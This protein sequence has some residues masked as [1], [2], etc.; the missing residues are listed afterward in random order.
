MKID[1]KQ[2]EPT[3]LP[4][5]TPIKTAYGKGLIEKVRYEEQLYVIRLT[6]W[7]LSNDQPVF[8]TLSIPGGNYTVDL[9]VPVGTA[10]TLPQG[11]GKV[12]S[13]RSTDGIYEVELTKWTL[14]GG[15]KVYVYAPKEVIA[16]NYGAVLPVTAAAP[17][18]AASST[19]AA[20]A[21]AAPEEP[22]PRCACVIA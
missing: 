14:S 7:K 9:P 20:R 13:Y 18:T 22:T 6:S 12:V 3:E 17:S 2:A 15:Q 5:G 19:S 21:E 16:P 10:V 4:V 8:V 11:P 1:L